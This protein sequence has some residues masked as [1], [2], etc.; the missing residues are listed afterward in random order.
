M[1]NEKFRSKRQAKNKE[2]KEGWKSIKTG[3]GETLRTSRRYL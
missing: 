3:Y 2:V 1:D